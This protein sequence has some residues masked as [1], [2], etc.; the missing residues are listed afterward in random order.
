MS[1]VELVLVQVLVLWLVLPGL[2]VSA[3]SEVVAH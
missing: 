2:M 1:Q 3:S